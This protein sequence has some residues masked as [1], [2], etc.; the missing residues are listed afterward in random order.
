MQYVRCFFG[1]SSDSNT[2][3]EK[4]FDEVKFVRSGACRLGS[5]FVTYVCGSANLRRLEALGCQCRLVSEEPWAY[6]QASANHPQHGAKYV[7]LHKLLCLSQALQDFSHGIC[8]LDWDCYKNRNAVFFE[9]PRSDF[10][11]P[12]YYY[13]YP[14]TVKYH[15]CN[16]LWQTQL[17]PHTAY[18]MP[19][20]GFMYIADR[21]LASRCLEYAQLLDPTVYLSDEESLSLYMEQ[22]YGVWQG[23]SDFVTRFEPFACNATVDAG[24]TRFYLHHTFTDAGI[25]ACKSKFLCYRHAASR[26]LTEAYHRV[27]S[28]F[29]NTNITMDGLLYNCGL[30]PLLFS[31][32]IRLDIV[33]TYIF[34]CIMFIVL[35]NVDGCINRCNLASST[36]LRLTNMRFKAKGIVLWVT[37]IIL[38]RLS[39]V[40]G[41]PR[42]R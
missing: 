32:H 17:G 40:T 27:V 10:L 9:V 35:N 38:F 12:L 41:I 4:Y 6:E 23:H 7:L 25:N 39:W 2:C 42:A 21:S 16:S 28:A 20:A 36:L 26:G 37:Q 29:D 8:F 5:S 31:T 30:I 24:F 11:I 34:G 15:L 22:K 14:S 18:G 1:A 19:N 3:S 33:V 13:A